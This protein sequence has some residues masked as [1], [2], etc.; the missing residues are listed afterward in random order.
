MAANPAIRDKGKDQKKLY[1]VLYEHGRFAKADL[2]G[3][4][5]AAA[6]AAAASSGA[7]S[8]SSGAAAPTPE[9]DAIMQ[10]GLKYFKSLTKSKQLDQIRG[11]R[12][13][14]GMGTDVV[15]ISTPGKTE[16]LNSQQVDRFI[17]MLEER[18]KR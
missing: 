11:L 1:T 17:A 5:S 13:F 9:E 2:A 8:S 7:A 15:P 18:R 14:Q 6:G 3:A 4:A 12:R 16:N 10:R